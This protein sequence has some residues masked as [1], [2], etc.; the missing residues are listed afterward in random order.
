MRMIDNDLI[1]EQLLNQTPKLAFNDN[2]NYSEWKEKV[3]EKFI[4][5][6]GIDNIAKNACELKIEIEETVEF[7]EYTRIRYVFESEKGCPVPCY[8]LIPKQGKEKYPICVCVQGHTTGFHISIGK[9]I[10]EEDENTLKTSTYALDAVKNGFAALCVEQRGMGERTTLRQDR[11]RALTCGCY[12]TSMTALLLGRTIIGERVWDL[13]KAIDTLSNFSDKLD[14]NDI[15][16][17]GNSGGGTATY[18]TSC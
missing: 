15:T 3:R 16:M 9:K 14:L 5:I 7:D 12:F 1:H 13:S 11:G 6:L 4:E 2:A 8:L 18:Y 17:L 10:Y